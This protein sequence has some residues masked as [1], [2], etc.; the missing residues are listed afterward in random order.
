MAMNSSVFAKEGFELQLFPL[1]ISAYSLRLS[2]VQ[3]I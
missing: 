3:Y 1:R 2:A